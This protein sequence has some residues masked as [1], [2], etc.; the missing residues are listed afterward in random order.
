[1]RRRGCPLGGLELMSKWLGIEGETGASGKIFKPGGPHGGFQ[2]SPRSDVAQGHLRIF[3][4]L[5]F[6]M[7][8]LLDT[9]AGV[10]H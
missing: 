4:R 6:S 9:S 8:R 7:N 5:L 3:T 1:M 10:D 2:Q